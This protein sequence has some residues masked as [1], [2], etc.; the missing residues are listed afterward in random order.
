MTEKYG[1]GKRF[2]T[3]EGYEIEIIEKMKQGKRRVRFKNGYEI[4]CERTNIG[5]GHIRNPYHPSV[6]GVGYL[7]VGDYKSNAEGRNAA[8]YEVWNKMLQRCYSEKYQ[9]RHPT[10]IGTTVC[11]EWLNF[12]NFAKW[13]NENYPK[14]ESINFQLDKDLLQGNVENKIYSPETCVFLPK[15]VNSFLA[16]KKS[17]NS[18]GCPGVSWHK[19]GKKW[20]ASINLFGE[21]KQKHLGIY[22]DIE[23]ASK[24]YQC[25]RELEAEKVKDYLR[26]LN[27]L[28]ENIIQLIK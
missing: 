4:I 3:N 17:D 13:Y 12:Q 21:R 5:L 25:A 28:P 6:Y 22:S 14:I 19:T 23:L 10:Y 11:N 27:Y 20:G 26:S 16:N 24:S 2:V 1:I 18:S 8:E 15:S 9:K 7:G